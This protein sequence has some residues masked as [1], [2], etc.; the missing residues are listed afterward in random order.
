MTDSKLPPIKGATN[1]SPAKDDGQTELQNTR[2]I[3]QSAIGLESDRAMIKAEHNMIADVESGSD[4]GKIR[5]NSKKVTQ[6]SDEE[7]EDA[8]K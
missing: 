2:E 1:Q 4:A 5:K 6:A 7:I 3:S 8:Q